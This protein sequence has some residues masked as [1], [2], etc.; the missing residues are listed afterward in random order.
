MSYIGLSLYLMLGNLYNSDFNEWEM[1]VLNSK[2]VDSTTAYNIVVR[3]VSEM[4][5]TERMKPE[6]ID[7]GLANLTLINR[8]ETK[9]E[10]SFINSLLKLFKAV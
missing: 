1:I 8:K 4:D 7:L 9:E 10:P 3:D 2:N 6:P 5:F